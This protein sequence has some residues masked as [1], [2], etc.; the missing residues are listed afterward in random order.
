M[1]LI[2]VGCWLAHD[3]EM[4]RFDADC[5]NT[6]ECRDSLCQLRAGYQMC[7][8]AENGEA[9]CPTGLVC[10]LTWGVCVSDS[11]D[12]GDPEPT[13]VASDEP[14]DLD[15]GRFDDLVDTPV[16]E[17]DAADTD[18]EC[19]DSGQCQNGEFCD[20][21]EQC[22]E[23]VCTSGPEPEIEDDATCTTD[24]CDEELNEI[25][26][27]PVDNR[28][29][30]G[31]L[32]TVDR[33]D[34]ERQNTGDGSGCHLEPVGDG[35]ACG[36]DLVCRG[37]ECVEAGC[38]NGV[39]E[40]NRAE[41]CDDGGEEDNDG[42]SSECEWEPRV[43]SFREGSVSTDQALVGG[44]PGDRW[45]AGL[46]CGDFD[47]DTYDDLI[48]WTTTGDGSTNETGSD[49]PEVRVML[50]PISDG[51]AVDL[52]DETA[53]TFFS[54][55]PGES[56]RVD[57]VDI[58]TDGRDDLVVSLP[59][60]DD[61]V[62]D[63][64][65]AVFVF[66]G[67]MD[68]GEDIVMGVDT[69]NI[70]YFGRFESTRVSAVAVEQMSGEP[71]PDLIIRS[72]HVEGGVLLLRTD[73]IAGS[74]A[75]PA[76]EETGLVVREDDVGGTIGSNVVVRTLG[77]GEEVSLL[78][79]DENA[80]GALGTDI[81]AGRVYAIGEAGWPAIETSVGDLAD[82]V[83]VG[84]GDYWH[85]D[86]AA[87]FDLNSMEGAEL[88]LEAPGGTIDGEC[89]QGVVYVID[90]SSVE[91]MTI[92]EMAAPVGADVQLLAGDC[93]E[94]LEVAP[95][96]DFNDDGHADL[97]LRGSSPDG[98]ATIY[99]IPYPLYF[100]APIDL[101]GE[102]APRE[103]WGRTGDEMSAPITCDIDGDGD[104]EFLFGV[105]GPSAEGKGQLW[106]FDD[107]VFEAP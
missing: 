45:G 65:G 44:D 22:V 82:T 104:V 72:E 100:G 52:A 27:E 68:A 71:N 36:S 57:V 86:V 11:N 98:E 50:G 2:G 81:A 25:V 85:T 75:V 7:G 6:H 61:T 43:L 58:N 88:V 24:R 105:P 70:S 90:W 9:I 30:D 31:N 66:F 92:V 97:I 64:V 94:S 47:G 89:T 10:N 1:L 83:F 69:A 91:E 41:S 55:Q 13:D 67:S 102:L 62:L 40:L 80:Y 19:V 21:Q 96:V 59:T 49:T 35:T 84:A 8:Q 28:C 56:M 32:C 20:G 99:L 87:I 73:P 15:D 38:G 17:V 101:D 29:S 93:D 54:P 95:A 42:C 12:T 5:P 4:C 33:C 39:V 16:V 48:L 18:A 34:P 77:A 103:I 37:T 26:H 46:T 78:F 53:W 106:I 79:G 107:L 63:E 74:Y 23:G 3:R 51:A 60:F 76:L 14:T